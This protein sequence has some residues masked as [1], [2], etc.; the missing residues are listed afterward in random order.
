MSTL[1]KY[2]VYDIKHRLNKLKCC[3]AEKTAKLVDKQKYG[4][5]CENEKCN[6]QLLGAYIEMLECL[7]SD[8]CDCENEWVAS[9][10]LV[11][12][13]D[14]PTSGFT[15]DQVVKVYPRYAAIGTD[16][17]L[18][19]RWMD[20]SNPSLQNGLVIDCDTC[21]EVLGQTCEEYVLKIPCWENAIAVNAW[22]VCGNTKVAWQARGQLIWAPGYTYNSGDIVKFMGGGNGVDQS[23]TD[24][25]YICA[26]GS[27][28]QSYFHEATQSP[29]GI[30]AKVWI[31]LTCYD[32]IG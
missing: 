9:G 4:K 31:E 29:N 1:G 18:Y 26:V 19:M 24:R 2:T 30:T 17:F 22:S 13:T 25:Y 15:F 16:E 27:D 11:Y 21:Q 10:S 5:P 8:G 32:L 28:N 23:G 7:V 6:V 3:F 12:H 20:A 14:I